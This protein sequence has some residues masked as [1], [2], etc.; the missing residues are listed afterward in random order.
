MGLLGPYN[1]SWLVTRAAAL[2]GVR[3]AANASTTWHEATRVLGY[4]EDPRIPA[5]DARGAGATPLDVLKIAGC[6][7]A[8][9]WY[10]PMAMCL[11]RRA[12]P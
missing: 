9:V 8:D 10:L 1:R 12:A 11:Q 5:L 7:R 4:V 3:C 2:L 6:G